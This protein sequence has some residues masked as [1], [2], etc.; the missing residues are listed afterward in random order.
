MTERQQFTTI[1]DG[2]LVL[3]PAKLNLSLLIASKRPDGFHEIE[4][5][6]AKVSY[7]DELLI[8]RGAK[9]GVELICNGPYPVPQGKDNLVYKAAQLLLDRAAAEKNLRITLTKNIP[10]GS[11]LGSASSDAAA[12][13]LG[14]CRFCNLDIAPAELAAI[15]ADLGSDIPF[16][17]N[18]PLALCKGRGEK[19]QRI[20]GKFSFNALIAIP[21]VSVSTKKVY[22]NYRHEPALYNGLH[23]EITALIEENSID[24]AAG[25]CANMLQTSCFELHDELAELRTRIESLGIGPLCLSGSGSAMF[26]IVNNNVEGVQTYRHKLQELFGCSSIIVNNISW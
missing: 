5:L 1:D 2:L 17:L 9:R 18:G 6:M 15:A 23:R 4:T 24:L 7:F 14:L 26:C 20:N 8:A 11:G 16:F 22:A 19:I 25:L 13:L 21:N 12:T 3:A 10:A